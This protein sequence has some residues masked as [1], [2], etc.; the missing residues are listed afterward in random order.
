MVDLFAGRRAKKKIE[1]VELAEETEKLKKKHPQ[2]TFKEREALAK[3]EF[4]KK[5]GKSR[6]EKALAAGAKEIGKQV[7]PKKQPSTKKSKRTSKPQTVK[8]VVEGEK[9]TARKKKRKKIEDSEPSFGMR[10]FG[11]I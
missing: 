7:E 5:K 10:D 8:V 1:R 11:R 4:R 3:E 6:V 9:R 2:L